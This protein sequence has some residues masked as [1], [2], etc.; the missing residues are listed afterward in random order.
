MN[1][2]KKAVCKDFRTK[3]INNDTHGFKF[4]LKKS[5]YFYLS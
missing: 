1:F 4:V 2:R 3:A 5:L